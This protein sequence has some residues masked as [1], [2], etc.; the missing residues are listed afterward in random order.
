MWFYCNRFPFFGTILLCW[1][2]PIL[3]Q[4][5]R[6][7]RKGRNKID[8]RAKKAALFLMVAVVLLVAPV[9]F[10]VAAVV[11]LDTPVPP[12]TL[13]ATNCCSSAS[14]RISPLAEFDVSVGP[15]PS[16]TEQREE[17]RVKVMN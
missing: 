11:A 14:E 9:V 13:S 5:S 15:S 7:L 6:C 10:P 8:A 1:R 4:L 17:E 16:T 3:S 12:S 2:D